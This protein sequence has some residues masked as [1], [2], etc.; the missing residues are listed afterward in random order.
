[1]NEFDHLLERIKQVRGDVVAAVLPVTL[2]IVR[3]QQSDN[4]R[5][6]EAS[7]LR[8]LFIAHG[9]LLETID[10]YDVSVAHPLESVLTNRLM[11]VL[12]K[13]TTE[14]RSVDTAD[15]VEQ[16]TDAGFSPT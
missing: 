12:A 15:L 4:Q 10:R 9:V 8:M 3:R 2:S 11:Q 13:P 14:Q 16:L 1:M 5:D 6:S 7:L